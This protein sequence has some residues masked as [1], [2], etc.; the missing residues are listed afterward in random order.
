MAGSVDDRTGSRTSGERG[1]ID[2]RGVRQRL[3]LI[4]IL[5]VLAV[6]LVAGTQNLDERATVRFL[7]WSFDAPLLVFFLASAALGIL[8]DELV[9]LFVYLRRRSAPQPSDRPSR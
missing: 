3:S 7:L 2:W 5:L 1:G 6:V 9:R 4:L 8:A